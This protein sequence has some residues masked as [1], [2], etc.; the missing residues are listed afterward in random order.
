MSDHYEPS[1]WQRVELGDQTVVKIAPS[2]MVKIEQI[3]GGELVTIWLA[4]DQVA[5]LYDYLHQAAL[6][7]SEAQELP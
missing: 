2:G 7:Q 1:I 5:L 3:T 6:T 4:P